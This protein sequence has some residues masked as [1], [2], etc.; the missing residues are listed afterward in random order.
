MLSAPF[1]SPEKIKRLS[2][3]LDC[4]CDELRI[5]RQSA[6]A[7][8]AREFLARTLMRG[9]FDQAEDDVD[10]RNLAAR[11]RSYGMKPAP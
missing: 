2:D 1:Y 8:S 10:V 5:D 6:F 11:G 7:K 4:T 9:G 3:I